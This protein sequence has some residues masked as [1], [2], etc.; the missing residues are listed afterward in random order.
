MP[1]SISRLAA[2]AALAAACALAAC[3]VKGPLEP[4]PG[5]NLAQPAQQTAAPA[6]G[7]PAGPATAQKPSAKPKPL[8]D[9]F[10][11]DWLLK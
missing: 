8:Y 6:S 2:I 11:L 5:N 7:Q 4:P 10:F 3:G 1:R 9:S